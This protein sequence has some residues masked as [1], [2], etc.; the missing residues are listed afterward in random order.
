MSEIKGINLTWLSK[1]DLTNLNSGEGGSNFIDVKKYLFQEIE[2]PYVSGQAMRF[3]LKEAIRRISAGD[4]SCVPNDKGETCGDIEK[5]ILCDL[6]GYMST[7]KQKGASVRVS[8][9][10]VS[11]AMGLLPLDGNSTI[12]FLTRRKPQAETEELRGD[13]VNVELGVNIYKCGISIDLVKVGRREEYDDEA[14]AT[15]LVNIVD[16]NERKDRAAKLL[17][18]IGYISDYSKQSRLLTD[19]TPDVI[20]AAIQDRYSHRLQKLFILKDGELTVDLNR[21]SEILT[22]IKPYCREIHAGVLTGSVENEAELKRVF[23]ENEVVLST[24]SEVLR[25]LEG[26]VT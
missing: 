26:A 8:P 21:V 18:S 10:K 11:P 5:C 12:D 23:A 20:C 4:E 1:T 7:M 13:I 25:K 16:E 14:K 24:P 2:F 6:F 9:V 3:Y 15:K 19:F 22:D 17:N